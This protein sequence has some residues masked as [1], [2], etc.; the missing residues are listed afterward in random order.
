M[1]IYKKFTTL[2]HNFFSHEKIENQKVV[3]LF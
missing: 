3:I 2:L 1:I